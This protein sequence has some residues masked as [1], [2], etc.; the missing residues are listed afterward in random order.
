M[1]E[2][3]EARNEISAVDAE[4]AKLFERRMRAAAVIADYKRKNGLSVKD[5]AREEELIERNRSYI[6]SA[7]IES[8]MCSFSERR[9]TFPANIRRG[10]WR[11]CA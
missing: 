9:S 5:E 1:N 11:G 2:L 3:Q 8:Y 7:D 10:S 6:D 4:M